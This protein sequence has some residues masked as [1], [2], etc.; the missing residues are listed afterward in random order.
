MPA[1]SCD[2]WATAVAVSSRI[3]R[4]HRSLLARPQEVKL[5]SLHRSGSPVANPLS[6]QWRNITADPS[7]AC[8]LGAYM[9]VYFGGDAAAQLQERVRA[10]LPTGLKLRGHRRSLMFFVSVSESN[11]TA[12]FDQTPSV[13]ICLCGTRTVWL[14]PPQ[15]KE[16][17]GLSSRAGYPHMLRFDPSVCR[18]PHPAW[19]C[20]V[21]RAGQGVFIPKRWWHLVVASEGSIGMSLE[22]T[23]V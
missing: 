15:V 2:S 19:K 16:R 8:T 3:K 4:R 10:R 20:V 6:Q 17:C 13:L 21:L 14:A 7:I 1:A 22:V 18:N 23:D 12:H 9:K 5:L 11:S